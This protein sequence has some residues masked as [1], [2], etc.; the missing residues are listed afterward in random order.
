MISSAKKCTGCGA[1]Y[2][3]CPKKCISML[4][5]QE[6]FLYPM[7]DES[8]CVKCGKC[9]KV[10]QLE[11]ESPHGND[12]L[13][14]VQAYAI[15]HRN[16]DRIMKSA[17]GGAFAA[18]AEYVL[19][20]GGIVFGCAYDEKMRVMHCSVSS[21]EELAALQS[22]KYVQSNTTN[23]YEEAKKWLDAGKIVLYSGTPCQIAGLKLFLEKDY[24]K[25]Y[26]IDL[27]CHGVPSPLLFQK[28]LVWLEGVAGGRVSEYN[29][30]DKRRRGW[31][32]VFIYGYRIGDIEKF[33]YAENDPYFK[34]FLNQD[35]YRE[36]CYICPFAKPERYADFTIGD[37]W[38]IEHVHP[39]FEESTGISA[40]I[41]NTEKAAT[42]LSL[43]KHN[44]F[45]L[46]TRYEDIR[47]YNHN[48]NQP[49]KRHPDRNRIYQGITEMDDAAYIQSIQPKVSI[50]KKISC[51]IPRKYKRFLKTI[52]KKR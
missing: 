26:T 10:C 23:T 4:P 17:S 11:Q 24:E 12:R 33:N 35:T 8:Q 16:K 36:C 6:G 29:F 5:D 9:V 45:L 48:L 40:L 20:R 7:V 49:T 14:Q 18:V 19:D 52:L 51:W 22:S 43:L 42:L 50:K 3:A 39:E 37:Y 27:I 44:V 38:G 34:H 28:Y 2:Q 30:R 13:K 1:C 15:K 21:K 41:V 46:P 32:D 31:N 47:K 25:L